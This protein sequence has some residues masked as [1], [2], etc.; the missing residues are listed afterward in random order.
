MEMRKKLNAAISLFLVCILLLLYTSYA[1]LTISRAPEV[2]SIETNVG[3]NGSLEIAL[4]NNDT[5]ADPTTIRTAAGDSMMVQDPLVSNIT[6]GNVIDLSSEGYGLQ[7]ITLRPSRL[8]LATDPEG[9]YIVSSNM[10]MVADFGTD[11]R[12]SFVA[13]NTVSGVYA[14]DNFSFDSECQAHGVRGIGVAEAMSPRQKAFAAANSLVPMY[15]A[16]AI[17]SAQDI[18]RENGSTLMNMWERKVQNGIVYGTEYTKAELDAVIDAGQK[19]LDSYNYVDSAI[20]N[21]FIG[22]AAIE[23]T[24]E[25]LFEDFHALATR[26]GV[27]ASDLVRLMPQGMFPAVLT[28]TLEGL[29]T[30]K[31]TLRDYISRCKRCPVTEYNGY[32]FYISSDIYALLLMVGFWQSHLNDYK[33]FEEDQAAYENLL[34]DN[35]LILFEDSALHQLAAFTGNYNTL[36]GWNGRNVEVYTVRTMEHEYMPIIPYLAEKLSG[37]ALPAGP[38]K[39]D[40]Y[41]IYGFAVDMALRCNTTTDLLLQTEQEL[42]LRETTEAPVTQ[43]GGSYVRFKS[44]D[45]TRDQ[46]ISL[47]DTLR[48]GFLDNRSHLVALAKPN[49]SNYKEDID[50][51]ITAPLY[52]YEFTVT[53]DGAIRPGERRSEDSCILPLTQSSPEHLTSLLWMDGDYV[54]NSMINIDHKTMSG[55]VNLQF[56]SSVDLQ[57][58]NISITGTKEAS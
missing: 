56:A 37:L 10:L 33:L 6:W 40:I 14:E 39:A 22:V 26:P 4:L 20:C 11:G 30:V 3:A 44:E 46:Q 19:V 17:R 55:V 28:D 48:L 5:Y 18:W 50:G 27:S 2:S 36:F 32:N 34:E 54:D 15:N 25:D 7:D 58:S 52:L 49:V 43:G 24:E 47:I 21:A 51:S 45:M 41:D 12:V 38:L 53:D 42:R 1:W 13:D 29:D 57:P 23:L 31:D 35:T 16:S 8:N 9:N